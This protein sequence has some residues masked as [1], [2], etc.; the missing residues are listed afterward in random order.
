MI[1][2]PFARRGRMIILGAAAV[3][4][5]ALPAAVSADTTT[6]PTIFPAA[7]NGATV[8]VSGGSVLGRLIVNTSVDFTC[9]PFLVYDWETGTETEVTT[10][11]LEYG[12][13]TILQVAGRTINSGE[14]EFGGGTI[15]CDGSTMNHRDVAV[16]AGIVPWKS[17]SAVAGARVHLVDPGFQESHYASTGAVSIKLGS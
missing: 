12:A 7:S 9:D 13:V 4:A 3:L 15:V 1:H 17:G 10:G 11:S 6:T 5:L 16:V 8:H 2:M 14:A